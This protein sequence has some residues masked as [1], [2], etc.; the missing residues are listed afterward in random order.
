E[1]CISVRV[2]GVVGVVPAP[3]VPPARPRGRGGEAPP[4]PPRGAG[5]GKPLPF[6]VFGGGGARLVVDVKGRRFP[7]GP[8]KKPRR[9]WEC[10]SM[11]DDIDGL[12]RW[13]ALAGDDYRGV[14]AFAYLLHPSVQLSDDTPDLPVCRGKRY[15]FRAV[16]V[17]DY[18]E[19]MR[20]RSPRWNTVSL[21]LGVYRALVRPLCDFTQAST[22]EGVP[23]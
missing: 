7:G 2:C 22:V 5:G 13:S 19:H 17:T 11:R 4:P 8:P 15:L 14:L 10:W 9:V 12:Q 23:F 16:D 20:T 1:S 3:P 6:V 18:R 21:P